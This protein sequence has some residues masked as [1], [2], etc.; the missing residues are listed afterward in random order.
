MMPA[1]G[2][3]IAVLGLYR[4]GSSALAGALHRLGVHMG[5][6]FSFSYYEEARLSALLR[7][8]WNEPTIEERVPRPERVCALRDW[9]ADR[10]QMGA[11]AIGAKHPLLVLSARDVLEAWGPSTRLVWAHRPFEESVDSLTRRGW[12][13]RPREMQQILWDALAELFG[14]GGDEAHAHLR[15][16]FDALRADPR[17]EIGRIVEHLDLDP[18][19]E[20]MEAAVRFIRPEG[21]ARPAR[22]PWSPPRVQAAAEDD[23]PKL[24][25]ALTVRNEEAA[26]RANALY[27]HFLGFERIFVFDDRSEDRTL[28]SLEDLWYVEPLLSAAA[29]D[30]AGRPELARLRDVLDHNYSAKLM[31]NALTALDAAAERGCAWLAV[32]DADELVCVDRDRQE[33]GA[34]RS[35]FATVPPDVTVVRFPTLEV[36]QRRGYDKLLGEETLFFDNPSRN[37]SRPYRNLYDPYA[38]ER[39]DIDFIGHFVG[40][41]AVRVSERHRMLPRST[42]TWGVA[43]GAYREIPLGDLLHF[44]CYCVP[45]FLKKLQNHR[46][47]PDHYVSGQPVERTKTMWRDLARDPAS[48]PRALRRYFMEHV[49]LSD[50]AVT[51]LAARPGSPLLEV[52]SAKRVFD[53]LRVRD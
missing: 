51:A 7:R 44:N 40:K 31:L 19:P 27:H 50:D 49:A 41:T 46:D 20:Q 8:W 45:D 26:I 32:L 21:V 28:A 42:H 9:V 23:R 47:H 2:S 29:G 25:L 13:P 30:F 5:E 34:A 37:G 1:A 6:R 11:D 4:S 17:T 39:F 52:R 33:R 3:R 35:A 53:E 24:A 18:M 38:D 43:E 14:G 10:E 12:W 48:T 16:E 22:A 15:V 36:V